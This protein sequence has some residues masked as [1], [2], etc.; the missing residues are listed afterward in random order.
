M[1]NQDNTNKKIEVVCDQLRQFLQEKNRRYGDSALN[2]V[3]VFSK[4]NA[5]DKILLRMDDKI[6]R[7]KNSLALRKNDNV[8]LMGYLVLLCINEGWMDFKDQID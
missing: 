1:E 8:D 7:I 3:N 6:T 5:R 2:P 4:G